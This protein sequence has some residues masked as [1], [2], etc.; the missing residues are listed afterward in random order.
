MVVLDGCSGIPFSII[1]NLHCRNIDKRKLLN[2]SMY[3]GIRIYNILNCYSPESGQ[4]TQEHQII[5]LNCSYLL[6]AHFDIFSGLLRGVSIVI[7]YY[8]FSSKNG[9]L[10]IHRPWAPYTWL[11]QYRTCICVYLNNIE[12]VSLN[13]LKISVYRFK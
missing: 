3:I 12:Y 1:R 8:F 11:L 9:Y 10:R 13:I 2:E 6:K 7:W 4:Y 5:F